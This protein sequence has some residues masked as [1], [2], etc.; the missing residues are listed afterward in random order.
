[1]KNYHIEAINF[2]GSAEELVHS[3]HKGSRAK[4]P[5]DEQWMVEVAAR[6]KLMNGSTLRTSSPDKF[7]KDLIAQDLIKALIEN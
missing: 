2:K 6:L 7:I 4:C 3:L 1:M 5:T